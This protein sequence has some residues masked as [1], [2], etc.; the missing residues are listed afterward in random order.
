MQEIPD[1]GDPLMLYPN[2]VSEGRI[3]FNRQVSGTIY[4]LAG[5]PLMD[6]ELREDADI[7]FLE[8]GLYIFRSTEGELLRFVVSK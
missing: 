6:V 8:A 3:Q 5:Q 2:P 4:N 7:S 1:P